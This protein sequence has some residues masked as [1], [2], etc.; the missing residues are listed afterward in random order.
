[1]ETERRN[2]LES[3]TQNQPLEDSLDQLVRILD[4]Q[5][6]GAL[7][8]VLLL[9]PGKL[10][11]V[12]ATTMGKDIMMGLEGCR[13]EEIAAAVGA[14]PDQKE[15]VFVEDLSADCLE[16]QMKEWAVAFNLKSCWFAPAAQAGGQPLGLVVVLFHEVRQATPQER[17][18]LQ[19]ATGMAAI[20]I[21]HRRLTDRL[22][23][24]AQH[25]A[26]TGLPNRFLLDDRLQQ[27]VAFANRHES[28]VAVLLLDLDGF[29]Y[30]NDTLGHQA[31]DQ[32]LVEV[33]RR[34]RSTTRQADTLARIG[35]DEF[36]LVLS[37]LREPNDA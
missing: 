14:N 8:S 4:S 31:G 20:A 18:R 2:F 29:K 25:D 34:L 33:A 3:I 30:V 37:D 19:V 1:M 15:M 21:E 23:Y 7:C 13:L 27:A 22:S 36:C 9:K 16:R 32:V 10:C 35:G 28:R 5:L 12:A 11:H 17:N 24:Q 26:L 6:E